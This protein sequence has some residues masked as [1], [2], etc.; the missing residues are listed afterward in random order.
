MPA[1][2]VQSWGGLKRAPSPDHA[3]CQVRPG[4]VSHPFPDARLL[5]HWHGQTCERRARPGCASC[6]ARD[7]V[8]HVSQG[9]ASSIPISRCITRAC[10]GLR[11]AAAHALVC[12]LL[13][14]MRWPA[15]FFRSHRPAWLLWP[16][17]RLPFFVAFSRLLEERGVAREDIWQDDVELS[18]VYEGMLLELTQAA[19]IVAAV[20]DPILTA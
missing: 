9:C 2:P 12:V 8:C 6:D 15:C 10:P 18:S 1:C 11:A 16:D 13:Q 20:F 17:T 7:G 4:L 14:R 3:S 5:V 19:V